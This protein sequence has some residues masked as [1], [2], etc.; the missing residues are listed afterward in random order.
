MIAALGVVSR[1]MRRL[2]PTAV[3][4]GAF[5][6]LAL[7][8]TSSAS[9][10]GPLTGKQLEARAD[11]IFVGVA[12]EGPTETGIQ[13]FR[14]DRYLKGAG[15][16]TAGVATGVVARA[17]GSGSRVST[18]VDVSAGERWQVYATKRSG[19][20]VLETGD[21][22]GSGKLAFTSAGAPTPNPPAAT[23]GAGADRTKAI[24]VATCLAVLALLS[25]A[26]AARGRLRR[27]VSSA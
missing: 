18:A 26:L 13:R 9:C 1:C 4:T 21:C 7:P 12:L 19:S 23:A 10:I 15:P 17:D 5:L 11:V 6:A 20:D 25:L 27:T 24:L 2:W 14:V 8:A 3:L 22:A 16:E